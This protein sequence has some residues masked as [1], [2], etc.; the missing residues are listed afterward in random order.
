MWNGCVALL[1]EPGGT[2]E[3]AGTTSRWWWWCPGVSMVAFGGA[4]AADA[5]AAIGL[6]DGTNAPGAP[7]MR[8]PR[9]Q[10]MEGPRPPTGGGDD[11]LDDAASG[12][13]AVMAVV[14]N[15][16]GVC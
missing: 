14:F 3:D 13:A 10:R 7:T 1:S 15:R 11:R 12:S 4:A 16:P 5:D 9:S 6:A 2:R 8:P